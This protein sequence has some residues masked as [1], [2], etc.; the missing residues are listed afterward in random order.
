[1]GPAGK[2]MA[3]HERNI[4]NGLGMKKSN[5]KSGGGGSSK[6]SK[7][8]KKDK[9]WHAPQR[10][11][12]A[13]VDD[14]LDAL[15]T[16]SPRL[17]DMSKRFDPQFA[18]AQAATAGARA[19]AEAEQVK[20]NA[21]AMREALFAGSPELKLA[22]EKMQQ[23]L[24]GVGPSEI[25]T[26][27]QQQAMQDLELGGQ[28]SGEEIT[29]VTQGTRAAYADRGLGMGPGATASEIMGRVD[30]TNA[31]KR[32]RQAFA[33]AVDT[34]VQQRKASDRG[35]ILNATNQAGATF[36]PYQ[37]IM[38]TGGSQ[39]TGASGVGG[40]FQNYLA[41]V[42]DVGNVNA[43]NSMNMALAQR[44]DKLSRDGMALDWQ[45][46]QL[47]RADSQAN[48]AANASA[49][50]SAQTASYISTGVSALAMLAMFI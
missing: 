42:S 27:L 4:Q 31:R 10:N 25:E 37:R 45:N 1:M 32:E 35:Y 41:G 9:G 7:K 26:R 44:Q 6:S 34:G 40:Q 2:R 8:K 28:L 43:T 30:L 12:S 50:K 29:Q 20:A 16:S 18:E 13:E 33:G 14:A 49:Q 39:T 46:M 23:E 15:E 3:K 17:L 36:D 24:N 21:P 47:N 19:A 22:S 48:A 11:F 38:G 5:S